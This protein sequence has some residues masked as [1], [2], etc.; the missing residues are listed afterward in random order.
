MKHGWLRLLI[1]LIAAGLC[2]GM[3]FYT[4]EMPR[5]KTEMLTLWYS[6]SDC[7]SAAMESLIT[8]CRKETGI[9][10]HATAFGD[11]EKLGAAFDG[12]TGRTF[13]APDLLFCSHIR[14]AH[15]EESGGLA[16]IASPLPVP[17]AL[18]DT[19]PAAGRSFFPIGFRLPL[20][21]VNTALTDGDFD[22]F[23]ALLEAAG[24][25]PFLGCDC[26]AAFFYTEAAAK[27]IQLTGDA[28]DDIHHGQAA[29]LYNRIAQAV[30]RGGLVVRER[31]TD[32]VRG[33]QLA[34][35][36]T[37][38]TALAGLTDRGLDVRL[39]PL[40]AGTDARYPAELMGFALLD[41]A[42]TEASERFFQWL[43][44]GSGTETALAA[45]M[46][47]FIQTEGKGGNM[48]KQLNAVTQNAA[49]YLTDP[50]GA[51][52]RNREAF[53]TSLREALDLLV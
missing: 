44:T 45:G 28:A 50:D 13:K 53:E 2:A 43:W 18:S 15:F 20:L 46:A 24:E 32:Y 21:L 51:F 52:T 48:A 35:T 23:E 25:T 6:E 39:L 40:P 47:P 9:Q 1:L 29:E 33:G 49:I 42:D 5:Q 31:A 19:F 14:A 17:A 12:L 38:S 37:M 34:C 3:W 26:A 30:F 16:E 41:G 4:R 27:G 36:V 10:I 22:S 8:R 11:E 7:D